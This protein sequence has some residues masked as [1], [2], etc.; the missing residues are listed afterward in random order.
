MSDVASLLRAPPQPRWACRL[1]VLVALWAASSLVSGVPAAHAQ[2]GIEVNVFRPATGRLN[3]LSLETSRVP[4]AGEFS[5]GLLY[6]YQ[7]DPLVLRASGVVVE[8]IVSDQQTASLYA[9]LGLTSFLEA[10][11]DLPIHMRMDGT[12]GS[13][14]LA[15][16]PR[17][18]SRSFGDLR[19]NFKWKLYGERESGVGVAISTPFTLSTGHED[20]FRGEAGATF[21]PHLIVDY[22]WEMA[23]L[24]AT[25]GYRFRQQ[26]QFADLLVD[27]EVFYGVGLG[28]TLWRQGTR[29]RV[30]LLAELF[31]HTDASN[32]FAVHNQNPMELTAAVRYTLPAADLAIVAGGGVGLQAGYGVPKARA[33]LG[34][35]WSPSAPPRVEPKPCP[36]PPAPPPPPPCPQA[37]PCP[38]CASCPACARCP[39]AKA[40]P[41][42]EAPTCP[43]EKTCPACEAPP[44]APKPMVVELRNMYFHHDRAEPRKRSLPALD[45]L[46]GLLKEFPMLTIRVEGHTDNTGGAAYNKSLS[47]RRADA[48]RAY[49]IKRGIDQGRLQAAGRGAEVPVAT[50]AT[51]A[52]RKR[53]RRVEV[54]FTSELPEKLKVRIQALEL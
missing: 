27:D 28:V 4:D 7:R 13:T 17:L 9:S 50:N 15:N 21:A 18:A 11:M 51:G 54:H 36:P 38:T 49:L 16:P 31:G 43:A 25:L 42:A 37:K 30:G 2:T 5:V 23:W 6:M 34:V 35:Q 32:P 3:L 33:F 52:G 40:C 12:G 22:R 45:K 1:L 10:G 19:I 48:V 26:T 46:L 8:R 53:N 29:E 20:R 39:E 41:L 44:P 14:V 47:Q 24:S